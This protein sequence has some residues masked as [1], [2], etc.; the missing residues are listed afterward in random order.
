[1]LGACLIASTAHAQLPSPYA[2]ART[3][4]VNQHVFGAY[5]PIS[6][7]AVGLLSQLRM[8]FYPGVDFGFQGGVSKLDRNT[9]N[10]T[11]VRLG[12]DVKVAVIKGTEQQPYDV[13]AGG[14]LE[15]FTGDGYS[16]LSLGPNA[17]I[18][19]TWKRGQPGEVSPYVGMGLAFSTLNTDAADETDFSVPLRIGSE[20]S[21]SSMARIV[22]EMEFRLGQRTGDDVSFTA[23]VNLPF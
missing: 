5:I 13:S 9:G 2:G 11:V 16:L 14:A 17:T 6:A 21:I 22:A 1:M 19:R 23:G 7:H 3:L 10:R 12:T 15:V 8:S 18:S 20:Y 4:E